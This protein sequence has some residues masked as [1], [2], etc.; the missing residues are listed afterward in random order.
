MLNWLQYIQYSHDVIKTIHHESWYCKLMK[1][2]MKIL[3]DKK[4]WI[5]KLYTIPFSDLKKDQS[6][7]SSNV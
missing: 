4:Q 2:E 3:S 5:D 1:N 6:S 7:M